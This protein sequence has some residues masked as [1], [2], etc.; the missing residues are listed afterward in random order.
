[1]GAAPMTPCSE[2]GASF[3]RPSEACTYP[4]RA[5]SFKPPASISG[6]AARPDAASAATTRVAGRVLS[7]TQKVRSSPVGPDGDFCTIR[8]R[9]WPAPWSGRAAT[10]LRSGSASNRPHQFEAAVRSIS[11][12]PPSRTAA[13]AASGLAATRATRP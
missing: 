2:P 8:A 7:V 11:A 6:L 9:G 5:N 10:T 1:M 12:R 4:A 3:S 13:S